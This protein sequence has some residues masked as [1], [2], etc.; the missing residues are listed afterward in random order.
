MRAG[1]SDIYGFLEPQ[2]IQRFH[3]SGHWQMVI[4]LPKEHLV[5]WFCSLHNR[6]DNYLK[7]IINS[8]IKGLDDAPQP[9]SKAPA[10]WI[11][12]KCNRQ[13]GTTECG[14][15][16]MHWMST[17]ILGSFRN[18]WEAR[19]PTGNLVPLDSKI[20]ATLRRNRAERRRKLLQ[21]RTV[22]FILEEETHFSDSSSFHSPSSRESVTYLPE[23]VSMADEHQQRV[24]LEDYSSREAKWWLYSFKGNSLKTWEEVVD[25]FLKKYFP[26]SE[27]TEGKAAISSF[28]QFPDE[29][30][31]EA[32][33]RWAES[34]NQAT[35][36]CFSRGKIKLKTPEEATE[37]IENMSASNHAILRD[38][39]H[40][41]A[42]KSLLELSSH[43]ALLAQNKLLSKQLEIL[44]ETLGKLPTKLSIGQPTHSSVLQ[45]TETRIYSRR[46]FRLL[47]SPYNQ[48]GQWRSHPGNQF[49]KDQGGPS[50]RPIQQGPIIFQRTTKLEETLTQFMQITMSNHKS[51]ESALKNLEVQVGQ[52]ANQIADKSANS[53]VVNIEKNL[54]EECKAAMTRSK[55][56]VEVEDEDSVVSKKKPVEKKGK[57]VP[58]H[59]V[60]SKKEKDRHLA[61]FLDIFRKLEITMPFG[62]A[63]QQMP[64]YSKF[65][66][67]MLTRKH[68]YIHQEN[69]VVEGNCSAVIQKILP[70]KH[71][72]PGSVM[73]LLHLWPN[74]LGVFYLMP[75][76]GRIASPTLSASLVMR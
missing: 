5:V 68:K 23:A 49:N 66:K 48:Q 9:K 40:Q 27:T 74:L 35:V 4:I 65:L 57:E 61:R 11:V 59:V 63:L 70:P 54:K 29:S 44:T 37:L 69:I 50:N 21:D 7:G 14:Y 47:Q 71:K 41:L 18:N 52:L 53:F 24:T 64:L 25:K 60:P 33:E 28:H 75:L 56:F 32:L 13:K 58:Y 17:I 72:D 3:C 30:L 45:V 8:A 55:R 6:P 22:V 43:D 73:P 20:E 15:Y 16:V 31:S 34:T 2:S 36:R 42:K 51:T 67:D 1:N 62:E 26:E 39:V 46:I 19:S 38:R 12:V 76:Q 10:R